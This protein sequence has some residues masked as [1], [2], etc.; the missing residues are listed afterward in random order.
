MQSYLEVWNNRIRMKQR[1][2]NKQRKEKEAL[3]ACLS[4]TAL[5]KDE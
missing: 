4:C 1:V 2:E 3:W 5:R